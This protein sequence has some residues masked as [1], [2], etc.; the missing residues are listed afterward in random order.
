MMNDGVLGISRREQDLEGRPP[1]QRLVDQL[2]AVQCAGHDYVGEEQVDGPDGID[3]LQGFGG[4]GRLERGVAETRDLG[5]DVSA[6]QRI[7][8]DDEDDFI[9]ALDSRR[10]QRLR[11]GL[12]QSGCA[13]QVHLDGSAVAFLAV[14]LDIPC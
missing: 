1:L 7:V 5:H 14:D 3:N 4:I 2:L 8:F 13:R 6:H 9:T 11:G 12:V 10:Y